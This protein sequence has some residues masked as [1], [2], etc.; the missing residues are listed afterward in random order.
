MAASSVVFYTQCF[1]R[2]VEIERGLDRLECRV[3]Q[4]RGQEQVTLPVVQVLEKA[5]RIFE[6][7][8]IVAPIVAQVTISGNILNIE[9]RT[10]TV[11]LKQI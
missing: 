4:Y 10:F 9:N 1:R 3:R 2:P 11:L 6:R 7:K 8:T 5:I